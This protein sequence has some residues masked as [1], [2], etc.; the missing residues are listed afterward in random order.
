MNLLGMRTE[1]DDDNRA[2]QCERDV[3]SADSTIEAST[4]ACALVFS[5]EPRKHLDA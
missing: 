5:I 2:T 3:S 1:R 4:R